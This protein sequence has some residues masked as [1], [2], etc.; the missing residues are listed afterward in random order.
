MNDKFEFELKQTLSGSVPLTES[1]MEEMR[2]E[3]ARAFEAKKRKVKLWFWG[4]M[5]LVVLVG[6]Y[7]YARFEQTENLKTALLWA[8]GVL[9][10][11][12]STVL[13]KLWYWIVH[14]RLSLVEEMKQIQIQLAEQA[15]RNGAKKEQG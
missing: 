2:N 8:I 7:C 15:A 13:M 11:Y 5:V 3:L 9:V 10:M 14:T 6:L 4:Y 1:R 12:E